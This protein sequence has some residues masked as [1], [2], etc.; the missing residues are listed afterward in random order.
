MSDESN[1]I[2]PSHIA[3][4]KL[5]VAIADRKGEQVADW[6]R[7]LASRGVHSGVFGVSREV[8]ARCDTP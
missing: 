7:E 8:A 2:K 1:T 5:K 3:A 6:I 4:A